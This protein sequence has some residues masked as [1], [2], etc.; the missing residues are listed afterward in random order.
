MT[1]GQVAS[2]SG[3]RSPGIDA[4][5]WMDP[6]GETRK[7]MVRLTPEARQRHRP[8]RSCR[9]VVP[10]GPGAPPRCRSAR[11]RGSKQDIGPAV[12]NHLDRD[13]VVN[14]GWNMAGRSSG[15]IMA[16]VNAR[17]ATIQLP[18]G[19]T[20]HGG[21]AGRAADRGVMADLPGAGRRGAAHVPGA[22]DAVRVVPRSARDHDVAAAVAHR[23]HAGAVGDAGT[24]STS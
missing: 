19:V 5:D 17:L 6:G 16:D 13:P 21:W 9:C 11:W 1:V 8:A 23:R 3:P 10:G 18:A 15:E 14:V 7:V 24:R 12:I 2:R 20:Y 22:R 4:G